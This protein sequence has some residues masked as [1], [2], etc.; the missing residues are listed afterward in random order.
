MY[1]R[2]SASPENLEQ[3]Q[4]MIDSMW[5]SIRSAIERAWLRLDAPSRLRIFGAQ[6]EQWEKAPSN[7]P[8]LTA[9]TALSAEPD[10]ARRLGG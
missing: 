8:F 5:D 7:V 2:N 9:L 3:N 6:A 1:I 4:A 10:D